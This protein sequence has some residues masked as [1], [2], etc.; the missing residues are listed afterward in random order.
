MKSTANHKTLKKFERAYYNL[1]GERKMNYLQLK[2]W[3][4]D[5][6]KDRG[7]IA[8]FFVQSLRWFIEKRFFM[9]NN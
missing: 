3:A 8:S 4:I 9:K 7:K 5:W 1:K 6:S 2:A